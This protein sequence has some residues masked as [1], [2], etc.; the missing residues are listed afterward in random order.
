M[1]RK[2]S[3]HFI[4][5][6]FLTFLT[7]GG[8]NAAPGKN[9]DNFLKVEV[10]GK[11][12]AMAGT[13]FASEEDSFAQF[14]NPSLLSGIDRREIGFTHNEF[15]TDIRQEVL[16]YAHPTERFGNF[17]AAFNYFTP[18]Q[19]DGFDRFGARTES[20]SARNILLSGSWAKSWRLEF[21]ENIFEGISSGISIKGLS[22]KLHQDSTLG[23]ALDMG[24]HYTF[25]NRYL[26]NL[27]IAGSIQNLG[28]GVKFKSSADSLPQTLRLGLSRSWFGDA[29]TLTADHVKVLNSDSHQAAAI[30]YKILKSVHLRFGYKSLHSLD[31]KFTYGVGFENPVLRVDY[32]FV[33]FGRVGDTHRVSAIFRFGKSSRWITADEHLKIR[34]NEAKTFY[35]QGLLMEAFMISSQIQK[36]APWMEENN[37]FLRK[38]Q[39]DFRELSQT[40]P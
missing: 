11:A 34:F 15:I 2:I 3:K 1:N 25:K 26:N 27:K 4:L 5:S 40:A 39:K 9:T 6:A 38:I 19:I 29:L 30:Q 21:G 10:G 8:L 16:T 32:A 17:A 22:R 33:P 35:G 28:P 24:I 7:V 13:Q 36:V 18:G 12:S 37:K 20:L 23:F 14:Y 31:Q